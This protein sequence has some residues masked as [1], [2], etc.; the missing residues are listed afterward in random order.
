MKR[1]NLCRWCDE[2]MPHTSLECILVLR[3]RLR[4]AQADVERERGCVERLSAAWAAQESLEDALAGGGDIEAAVAHV[5]RKRM[6]AF[7]RPLPPGWP[8][9]P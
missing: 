3:D 9:R 4:E 2:P 6:I 7:L 5:N 1:S 8:G